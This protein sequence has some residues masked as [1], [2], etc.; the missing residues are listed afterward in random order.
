MKQIL[1]TQF[2]GFN[3]NVKEENK[4]NQNQETYSYFS[5][6]P[7][8]MYKLLFN[9]GLDKFVRIIQ[10]NMSF[11]NVFFCISVT[12]FKTNNNRKEN[13]KNISGALLEPDWI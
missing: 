2:D 11:F 7:T 8:Y 13:N 5:R 4:Q 12:E 3:V 10:C 9:R 1:T 6:T